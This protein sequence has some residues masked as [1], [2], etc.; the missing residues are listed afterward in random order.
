M[1]SNHDQDENVALREEYKKAR[2][3]H[4]GIFDILDREENPYRFNNLLNRYGRRKRQLEERM[5]EIWGILPPEVRNTLK[6][7]PP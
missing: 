3:E 1:A 2:E 5:R 4:G 7:P 6:P